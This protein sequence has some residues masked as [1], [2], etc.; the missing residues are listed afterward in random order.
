MLRNF[1]PPLE[2]RVSGFD[3]QG[4]VAHQHRVDRGL[5]ALRVLVA[6]RVVPATVQDVVHV[7]HRGQDGV[8]VSVVGV[9]EIGDV[10]PDVGD[11][12]KQVPYNLFFGVLSFVIDVFLGTK[13]YF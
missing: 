3:V 4:A 7:G 11:D 2:V 9:F 8:D 10:F 6:Q 13:N 12:G 5:E 1:V